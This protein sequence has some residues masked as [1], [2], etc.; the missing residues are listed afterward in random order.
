MYSHCSSHRTDFVSVLFF[1]DLVS[2]YMDDVKNVAISSKHSLYSCYFIFLIFDFPGK[3]TLY[4]IIGGKRSDNCG[5][6]NRRRRLRARVVIA[7]KTCARNT[8]L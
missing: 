1:L 2:K 8:L 7:R 4:N 5:L 6:P 3:L